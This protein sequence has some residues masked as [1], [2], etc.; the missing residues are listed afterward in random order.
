MPRIRFLLAFFLTF[1]SSAFAD[2]HIES[3]ANYHDVDAAGNVAVQVTVVNGTSGAASNVEVSHSGNALAFA[4]SG[5]TC[6]QQGCALD[7]EIPAG[8]SATVTFRVHFDQAY[9]HRLLPVDARA[10]IRGKSVRYFLYADAVL[11]RRFVVTQSG[12]S[13]AGS[14]RA[15]FEA[16]S[17]DAVCATMP[18]AIELDILPAEDKPVIA[19]QLP[20]PR[21]EAHYVLIEGNAVIDGRAAGGNGFD[22][23]VAQRA[24]VYGLTIR[25]FADNAILLRPRRRVSPFDDTASALTVTHC[26]IEHNFRGVN[27]GPGWLSD[28]VIRDNVIRDNVRTAIFDWSEHD[29]A[30]A[31]RPRMRIERNRIAGNG[32]SGIFF[33]E[34]S[35]GALILDNVIESN[36][37][38]GIAVARGARLVR[39]LANSI[40]HNGNAAIDLGLDGPTLT[41]PTPQGDRSAAV[42]ESATYDPATNTT[43]I[44]GR[45]SVTPIGICD[46]CLT[47]AVSLYAN[48]A[49]EHGEFAEAE[50]Y[51]GEAEPK[52]SGFVFTFNGNLR[53]QYVTALA[54]RWV[55]GVGSDFFDTGELSKAF[56]VQ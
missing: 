44:T 27:I 36:R 28:A 20:L 47:H 42:I 39:I 53:G 9:G 55:N 52:G 54:T 30:G 56:L 25:N 4:Q 3:T 35:D 23:N 32:A 48:R 21:I 12:D 37:D 15:A 1:A 22:F 49:A 29:P 46:L 13:G 11:P 43:T 5:W 7:R 41:F 31:I 8:E 50:T 6:A 10:N 26:V 40:V 2:F 33:G 45:P 17:A 51:L 38:F 19:L 18:C 34:G 14:L 24:E 16:V